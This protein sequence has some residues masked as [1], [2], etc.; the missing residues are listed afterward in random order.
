MNTYLIT[1]IASACAGYMVMN[2]SESNEARYFAAMFFGISVTLVIIGVIV[3]VRRYMSVH[4]E[5]Q[6]TPILPTTTDEALKSLLQAFRKKIT[7]YEDMDEI[8]IWRSRMYGEDDFLL[9]YECELNA[10]Y[11]NLKDVGFYEN[12]DY[13]F[14][15]SYNTPEKTEILTRARN[16]HYSAYFNEKCNNIIKKSLHAGIEK[17]QTDILVL[18]D[19]MLEELGVKLNR[20]YVALKLKEV[21]IR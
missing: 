21:E 9:G 1:A 17:S 12:G 20:E 4:K 16:R 5:S 3:N 2:L 7:E 6:Q 13:Y 14:C 19:Y 18:S 11:K 10:I 8:G 15:F